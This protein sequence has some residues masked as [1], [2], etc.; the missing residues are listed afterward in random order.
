MKYTEEEFK[1]LLEGLSNDLLNASHHFKLYINLQDALSKYEREINQCVAF[2]GLTIDAHREISI[3]NLCRAYD[4]NPK[5][6]SL[7]ELIQII[8]GNTEL[9]DISKFRERLKDNVYVDS[10]AKT[11][12]EPTTEQLVEDLSFVSND[13][14]LVKKLTILRGNVIAHTNKGQVLSPKS[15]PDP[16]TWAEVELLIS[17]GLEIYNKYCSLFYAQTHSSTLIGED[18]YKQVL[19]YI[20]LGMKA[21]KFTNQI[22]Q[23]FSY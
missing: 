10:L 2:W 6:L 12:R 13:N 23:D 5:S 20:R 11:Q 8:Q 17:K 22:Q 4:H 7:K 1:K 15:N 3:L 18:D 9:F 21:L 14:P 16:L 19:K